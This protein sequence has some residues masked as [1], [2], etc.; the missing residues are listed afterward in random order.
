VTSAAGDLWPR[1]TFGA[2]RDIYATL[3]M[4]TQ[5]VGKVCLALTPLSNHFWNATFQV[6]ARGLTPAMIS[7]GRTAR[8]TSPDGRAPSSSEAETGRGDDR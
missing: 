8:P 4:W 5:V 1:L 6:T 3:Y 2:W 7:D